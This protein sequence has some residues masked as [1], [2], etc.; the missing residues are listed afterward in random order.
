MESIRLHDGTQVLIRRIHADDG[1]RLQAAHERLSAA[2]KYRRFLAPKPHLSASDVR[3]LVDVDGAS[4]VAL[5]AVLVSA[6]SVVAAAAFTLALYVL[7]IHQGG[8]R[9]VA[10]AA[11]GLVALVAA[12]MIERQRLWRF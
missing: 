6:P 3:Y 1:P 9:L 5:V 2:T 8:D 4:H 10:V 7:V 11:V 12:V